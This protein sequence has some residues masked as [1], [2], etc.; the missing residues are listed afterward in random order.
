MAETSKTVT[1]RS[2]RVSRPPPP[3]VFTPSDDEAD[4]EDLE[5]ESVADSES[6]DDSGS[7]LEGFVVPDDASS[8]ES[9]HSSDDED[10]ASSSDADSPREVDEQERRNNNS[11]PASDGTSSRSTNARS[12]FRTS[13]SGSKRRLEFQSPDGGNLRGPRSN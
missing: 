11:T 4:G 1:T 7:D 2:G 9:V 5:V 12:P 13:Q 10:E 3:R 6:D 8:D